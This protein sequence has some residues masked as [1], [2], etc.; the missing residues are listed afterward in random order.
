[1][2]AI[3]TRWRWVN[4]ICISLSRVPVVIWHD[5]HRSH[6]IAGTESLGS[7]QGPVSIS[8]KTFYRK[9]S[10][11]L[12]AARLVF[13]IV[14]SLWNLTG[15]SATLLPMCLSNFKAMRQSKVPISWLRDF[16]RSYDKTSFRIL[17]RGPGRHLDIRTVFPGTVISIIKIWRSW[18]HL[19][20][21]MGIPLLV[22]R[23]LCSETVPR[24]LNIVMVLRPGT[25]SY[26]D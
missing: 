19:I 7:C 2:V 8:E 23:H 22:K 1:M 13:R 12:E 9:I 26:P 20:F 24:V 5:S 11:S 16:T 18:D 17:K 3:L 10:W 4:A 25:P 15:T 21:R 6:P 14:R